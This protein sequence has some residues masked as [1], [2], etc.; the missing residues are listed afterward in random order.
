[1]GASDNLH[2]AITHKWMSLTQQVVF[3]KKKCRNEIHLQIDN[4]QK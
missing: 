2:Y 3:F 4:I 1:M